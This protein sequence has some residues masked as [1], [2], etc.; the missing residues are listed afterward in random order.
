MSMELIA[1]TTVG[2]GGAANMEFTSIPGTYNDLY[3]LI[4]ARAVTVN[5]GFDRRSTTMSLNGTGGT[6]VSGR[7]LEGFGDS[8][9][10]STATRIGFVPAPDAT[11]DTFGSISVYIS[12]YTVSQNKPN[13]IEY[14]QP[15]NLTTNDKLSMGIIANLWSNTAAVTSIS[16]ALDSSNFAQH[17]S[18][19]LYGITKGTDG[20]TTAT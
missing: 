12:N 7:T 16:L 11:A 5:S 4:S 9:S 2:S 19:S 3:L 14:S 20:I 13:S 15:N 6:G 18:A 1:T 17:S 10:S 8:V